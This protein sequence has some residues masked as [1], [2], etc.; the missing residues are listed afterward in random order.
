[1][2][3]ECRRC[4]TLKSK[5]IDDERCNEKSPKLSAISLSFG[6]FLYQHEKLG[7]QA[8]MIVRDQTAVQLRGV[9]AV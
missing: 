4:H 8:K 2:I 3:V 7:C 5:L 1:M 6:L 9:M